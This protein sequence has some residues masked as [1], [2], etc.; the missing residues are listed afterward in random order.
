MKRRLILGILINLVCVRALS[1]PVSFKD[2]VSLMS[3]N[4]AQMNEL[5]LTY[6]LSSRVAT[7]VMYLRNS[8]SEFYI[9]RINY[10]VKR[11]NQDDSQANFYLSAGAG[12]EKY[13]GKLHGAQLGEIVLDWESRKYYTYFDHIY[14]R[15]THDQN[16]LISG[17]DYNHSKLRLGFAP[18]LADY[19]DLNIWVIAQ[20]D[21]HNSSSKY[22]ATQFIR[23]YRKNVLWEIGAGF[24]GSFA[25]NFML[26]L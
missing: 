21:Q 14:I 26:H 8:N 16:S 19:E 9:P 20:I 13:N 5:L 2:A 7:G 4:S 18:F 22:E 1:H 15:R 3:Y 6:S 10:L 25:F 17:Q 24:D 23:F 11:W 12:E